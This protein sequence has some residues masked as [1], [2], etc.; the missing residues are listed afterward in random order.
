MYDKLKQEFKKRYMKSRIVSETSLN[1]A[2]KKIGEFED[3]NSKDVSDFSESELLDMYKAL[4]CRSVN[5]L[6]NYNNYLKS[7]CAYVAQQTG[8]EITL[9][10]NINKQ[11][12]KE[13]ISEDVKRNK[14]ITYEQLCDIEMELLNYTDMAIMECLWLG[15]AGKNM[16]DITNLVKENVDAT[17]MCIV[18]H[19]GKEY[20]ITERQLDLLNKAFAEK[21]YV[22]YGERMKVKPL[23]G[24]DCLY[25]IRDN[26]YKDTPDVRFRWIYRKIMI[27]REHVGYST[28]SMKTIQGSG[29]LYFIKNGMQE[30]GL[31]LREFLATKEGNRLMLQYGFESE[32][33]IDVVFDKFC[34]YI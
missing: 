9:F 25:K 12:L 32:G 6:Q 20:P 33:R 29:M 27:I 31:G 17:R 3:L 4:N 2:F 21:T 34:E 30:S 7:Y 11:V 24:E 13:C 26:A 8:K 10:E 16:S 14:Y 28:M 23:I 19:N 15:I 1:G 5:T 22:C 18:L